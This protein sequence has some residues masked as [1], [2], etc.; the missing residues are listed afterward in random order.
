MATAS[1][2]WRFFSPNAEEDGGGCGLKSQ[3]G[4]LEKTKRKKK[5]DAQVINTTCEKYSYMCLVCGR[6]A[7]RKSCQ[8]CNEPKKLTKTKKKRVKLQERVKAGRGGGEEEAVKN[9]ASQ[10][11]NKK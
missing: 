8:S 1:N 7:A 2:V 11:T 4:P 9:D 6:K 5:V 3:R 10:N